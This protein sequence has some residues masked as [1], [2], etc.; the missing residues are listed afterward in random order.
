MST[1]KFFRSPRLFDT[2]H[3]TSKGSSDAV[4]VSE[5]DLAEQVKRLMSSAN[6]AAAQQLDAPSY[7]DTHDTSGNPFVAIAVLQRACESDTLR[8]LLACQTVAPYLAAALQRNRFIVRLDISSITHHVQDIM[9]VLETHPSLTHLEIRIA[10]PDLGAL[11]QLLDRNPRIRNLDLRGSVQ[12]SPPQ[13]DVVCYAA[14][15]NLHSLTMAN[16]GLSDDRPFGLLIS[17]SRT[18]RHLNISSNNFT[19]AHHIAHALAN[20][21]TRLRTLIM[22]WCRHIKAPEARYFNQF[23]VHNY[24]LTMILWSSRSAD[25]LAQMT[26][27]SQRNE[28]IRL[29][30]LAAMV[31]FVLCSK[32]LFSKDIRKL[33]YSFIVP[34]ANEWDEH[35]TR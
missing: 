21:K 13:V 1:G 34:L 6:P 18:L 3:P 14:S 35:K 8:I 29:E 33:I 19:N 23:L 11:M 5:A 15:R 31:A 25:V 30:M 12:L 7:Y 2:T 9:S 24:Y 28:R 17:T 27:M 32:K 26:I 22:L 10:A 16:C 20:S 4:W